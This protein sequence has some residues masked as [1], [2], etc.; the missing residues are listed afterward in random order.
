M[1]NRGGHGPDANV[2]SILVV[3]RVLYT[4]LSQTMLACIPMAICRRRAF[5]VC[6][7]GLAHAEVF[8][9][10]CRRKVSTQIQF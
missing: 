9:Q 10:Q 2:A 6:T 7:V 1:T 5:L 8:G 4:Y 3:W